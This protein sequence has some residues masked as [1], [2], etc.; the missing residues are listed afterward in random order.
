MYFNEADSNTRYMNLN[1]NMR[2][3]T[4]RWEAEGKDR[5]IYWRIIL[6]FNWTD[7]G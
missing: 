5:A 7:W 3:T 4:N 6:K 1:D 2:L